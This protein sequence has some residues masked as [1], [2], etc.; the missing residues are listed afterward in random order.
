MATFTVQIEAGN[1]DGSIWQALHPAE[2]VESDEDDTT[3]AQFAAAVAADQNLAEGS[4]WRVRVWTG[5]D[6]DTGTEPAAEHAAGTSIDDLAAVIRDLHGIGTLDAARDVVT[7]HVDQIR[8]DADLWDDITLTLT[9]AG[10]ELVTTAIEKSYSIGAVATRTAQL[11]VQ[12]EETA[13]QIGA[14]AER[15]DTLI[16][17]LMKTELRRDDIASAARLTPARL[18]QIRN[19]AE[20]P[21]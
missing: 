20:S 2:T 10:V 4:N 16:R 11:L 8:D 14:L 3:A 9:P 21:Q 18:Y 13:A 6:A 7:V 19:A 12:L 17:A 5:P 15:R 1:A